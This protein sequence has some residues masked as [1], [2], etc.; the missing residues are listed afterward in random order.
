M[1][2]EETLNLWLRENS[3]T[4]VPIEGKVCVKAFDFEG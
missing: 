3:P 4:N 2:I 1:M